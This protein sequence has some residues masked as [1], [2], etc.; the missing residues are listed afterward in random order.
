[1]SL[2]AHKSFVKQVV[3][4]DLILYVGQDNRALNSIGVPSEIISEFLVSNVEVEDVPQIE[5]MDLRNTH[6][7]FDSGM[8]VLKQKIDEIHSLVINLPPIL[9][10]FAYDNAT[11]K[12]MYIVAR[13]S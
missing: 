4:K 13:K 11:F 12:I 7:F 2:V 1:M 9:V 8:D 5:S 3:G 6:I 10:S